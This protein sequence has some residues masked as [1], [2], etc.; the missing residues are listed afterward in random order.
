MHL[1]LLQSLRDV[2]LHLTALDLNLLYLIRQL[3]LA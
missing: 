2:V 1:K 3:R